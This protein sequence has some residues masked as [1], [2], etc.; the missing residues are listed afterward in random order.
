MVVTGSGNVDSGNGW[1]GRVA[2]M[3]GGNVDGGD[4]WW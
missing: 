3:G 2:V 1:W 4:R